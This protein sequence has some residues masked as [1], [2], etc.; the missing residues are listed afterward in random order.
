MRWDI[1]IIAIAVALGRT[2][3]KNYAGLIQLYTEDLQ[4]GFLERIYEAYTSPD[5][6]QSKNKNAIPIPEQIFVAETQDEN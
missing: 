2:V 6:R 5:Q 1:L 4:N 3:W